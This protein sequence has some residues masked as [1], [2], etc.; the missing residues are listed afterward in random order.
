MGGPILGSEVWVNLEMAEM[1]EGIVL[2]T[3]KR[4]ENSFHLRGLRNRETTLIYYLGPFGALGDLGSGDRVSL[5][6]LRDACVGASNE[7]RVN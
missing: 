6:R 1:A 4:S 5:V 2:V 3:G 7:G